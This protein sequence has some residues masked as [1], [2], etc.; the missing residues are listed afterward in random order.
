MTKLDL[1]K[2][3]KHLY[4]PSARRVDI[5]DIPEFNFVMV[6]GKIEPGKEPATSEA[7]QDALN[8]LYGISFTLKFISKLRKTNPID[9][10]IMALEGLW[11]TESGET[12]FNRK[13]K[14][15][16]TLMMMQPAHIT[17]EMFEQA[18]ENLRQKRGHIPALTYLRFE[19]FH[20]GLCMQIMHVGPYDLEPMTIARMN[21]FAR[22]QGYKLRGKHH[23]IYLGDPRRAKPEKLRTILRHPIERNV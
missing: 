8:V 16:W 9:Y 15:Q 21:D 6:D 2:E 18:V 22:E 19:A 13:D 4:A 5:V 17:N 23:E 7:F 14:W 3:F 11:W 12:D 10:K 1:R 20:E